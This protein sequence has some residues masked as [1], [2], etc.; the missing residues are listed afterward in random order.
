MCIRDRH[1]APRWSSQQQR[2][3]HQ[4]H[5]HQ[6][7]HRDQQRYSRGAFF[8]P[9]PAEWAHHEVRYAEEQRQR[10]LERE[11]KLPA[12]R[13][14]VADSSPFS[15]ETYGE[16]QAGSMLRLRAAGAQTDR[17][18]SDG[19]RAMREVTALGAVHEEIE[20]LIGMGDALWENGNIASGNVINAQII[21]LERQFEA[22][23]TD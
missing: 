4:H 15:G 11:R 21:E 23:I 17:R 3:E 16:G 20:V 6:L 19:S 10:H 13:R 8:D 18:E 22:E 5:Q 12:T 14:L 1:S 9:D 2:Q 7:Q